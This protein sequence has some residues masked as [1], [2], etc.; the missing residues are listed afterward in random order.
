MNYAKESRI[1]KALE[2]VI[3]EESLRG[4]IYIKIDH[5]EVKVYED[6]ED[7]PEIEKILARGFY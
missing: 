7:I 1:K 2:E 3:E 5:G 4:K 6:F